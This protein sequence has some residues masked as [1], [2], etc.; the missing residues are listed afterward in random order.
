M[1]ES[2]I[3][4]VSPGREGSMDASRMFTNPGRRSVLYEY[5]VFT[6]RPRRRRATVGRPCAV[7]DRLGQHWVPRYPVEGA[8]WPEP[9]RDTRALSPTKR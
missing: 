3:S 5:G 7:S 8:D 4:I 9:S 1:P 2:A 6:D